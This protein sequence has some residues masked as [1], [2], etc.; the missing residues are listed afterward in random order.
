MARYIVAMPGYVPLSVNALIGVR[1]KDRIRR[2]RAA[3]DAVARA[4]EGARVP[5]VAPP[6]SQVR[7]AVRLGIDAPSIP[8]PAPSAPPCR[9]RLAVAFTPGPERI[10]GRFAPGGQVPDPDNLNKGIRDSLCEGGWLVDDRPEWLAGT[11]PVIL[12][13]DPAGPLTVI[14]LEDLA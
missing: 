3:A 9:R 11:E 14:E 8:I 13:R 10:G 12:P 7:D 4:M 2:K 1:V 5:R 6:R